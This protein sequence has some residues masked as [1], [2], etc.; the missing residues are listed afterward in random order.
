MI[1]LDKVKERLDFRRLSGGQKEAVFACPFCPGLGYGVDTRGHF[2]LNLEKERYFCHRCNSKGTYNFLASKFNLPP[3]LGTQTY[4][5]TDLFSGLEQ[6]RIDKEIKTIY[7]KATPV[8]RDSYEYQY[9]IDRGLTP[10]QISGNFFSTIEG[11]DSAICWPL[12][13]KRQTYVWQCRLLKPTNTK[14]L[15]LPKGV[16]NT[17]KTFFQW[18]IASLFKQVYLVE[19]VFDTLAIGPQAIGALSK[20]V[21]NMQFDLLITSNILDLTVCLDRDSENSSMLIAQKLKSYLP[22]TGYLS[23]LEIPSMFKDVADIYKM[24]GREGVKKT[25]ERYT[26]VC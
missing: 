6:E 25:I 3:S 19:G 8:K 1:N 24:F 9:L 11:M 14:Y 13:N 2:Y 12:L 18:E 26:I 4:M 15:F 16:S 20:Y 22:K 17:K 10:E 21:S 23:W 7:E 5:S